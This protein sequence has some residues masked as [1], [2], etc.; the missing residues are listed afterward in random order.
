MAT[1]MIFLPHRN[2]CV[3]DDAI[4]TAYRLVRVRC[5]HDVRAVCL[6]PID[7]LL[8]RLAAFRRCDI[9]VEIKTRRSF[10]K[11]MKNVV[12]VPH[13]GKGLAFDRAAMFLICKN[14]RHDLTRVCVIGQ[15]INYRNGRIFGQFQHTIM[16]CC[17]DHDRIH[18][19]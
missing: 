12:T 14:V 8:L 13:P 1:G 9:D 6:C 18:I 3:G 19:A 4:R 15:C 10:H 16:R 11:R 5:G 2:P 7:I 17:A